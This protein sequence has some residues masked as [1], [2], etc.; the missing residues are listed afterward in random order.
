MT[1]NTHSRQ[2]HWGGRCHFQPFFSETPS[3]T[4][5]AS[6]VTHP[7]TGGEKGNVLPEKHDSCL[8]V[9]FHQTSA[10]STRHN[11]LKKEEMSTFFLSPPNGKGD[12][13]PLLC[14]GRVAQ[15]VSTCRS[16]KLISKV[17]NN[18]KK[19]RVGEI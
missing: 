13:N 17:P 16:E 4:T 18:W 6:A 7:V 19:L 1:L 15:V 3:V 8:I 14:S 2:K 12:S 11:L 9:S 10:I 5:Y